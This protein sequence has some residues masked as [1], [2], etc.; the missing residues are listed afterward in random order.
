[1]HMNEVL[2]SRLLMQVVDV[3]RHDQYAPRHLP[4]EKRKRVMSRVGLNVRRAQRPSPGVVKLMN[5]HWVFGEGFRRSDILYAIA[6]PD[7]AFISERV[8]AG[9]RRNSGARQNN[10]RAAIADR[11]AHSPMIFTNTRLFRRPSNSP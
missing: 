10:D 5:T 9:F 6:L 8:D 1:M 4:L 3:L 7:A 11:A 2:A